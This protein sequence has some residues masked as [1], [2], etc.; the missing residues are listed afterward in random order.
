M[1]EKIFGSLTLK[2]KLERAVGLPIALEIVKQILIHWLAGERL[3]VIDAPTL[4]ETKSLVRFCSKVCV[5]SV[6]HRIQLQRLMARPPGCD[7][8]TALRRINAQIPLKKKIEWCDYHIEN[9]G[10]FANLDEKVRALVQFMRRD[11]ETMTSRL[12]NGPS[13]LILLWVFVSYLSGST[14]S[15]VS[16]TTASI[17]TIAYYL[18]VKASSASTSRL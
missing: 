6:P 11:A 12:S 18:A 5:V 17:G 3:I 1:G 16:F 10:S 9:S 7:E 13:I 15:T 2:R 8:E 4:Y 14:T